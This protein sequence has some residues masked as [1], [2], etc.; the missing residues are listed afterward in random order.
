MFCSK[1][2]AEVANGERFCSSCGA[3]AGA[4]APRA[5]KAKGNFFATIGTNVK[6]LGVNST[7]YVGYLLTLVLGWLFVNMPIFAIKSNGL[8]DFEGSSTSYGFTQLA[9]LF[10]H[11][12]A[13]SR[14]SQIA[15]KAHRSV[16]ANQNR[17]GIRNRL[18]HNNSQLLVRVRGN[19]LARHR[20][21]AAQKLAHLLGEH[22]N[23]LVARRSRHTVG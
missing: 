21:S 15:A 22:G 17:V 23:T 19:E 6:N 5:P 3:P 1:C 9:G 20:D 18:R 14:L 10:S 7:L 2:G 16:V 8:F 11:L 12:T 4:A 13:H